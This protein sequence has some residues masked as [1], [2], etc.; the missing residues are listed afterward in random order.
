MF[1]S[2]SVIWKDLL[3]LWGMGRSPKASF[4]EWCSTTEG[5]RTVDGKRLALRSKLIT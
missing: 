3:Q 2:L 5:G 4:P 1:S